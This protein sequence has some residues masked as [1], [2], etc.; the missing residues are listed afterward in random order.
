MTKTKRGSA[1]SPTFQPPPLA[2]AQLCDPTTSS[3]HSDLMDY[4]FEEDG[5]KEGRVGGEGANAVIDRM[6]P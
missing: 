2:T 3:P 5:I 6:R 4:G 1:I